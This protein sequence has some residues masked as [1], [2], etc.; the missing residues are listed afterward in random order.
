MPITT[1]NPWFLSAFCPTF[2]SYILGTEES[3]KT[4]VA[5][6]PNSYAYLS[7][8]LQEKLPARP[9]VLETGAGCCTIAFF[10]FALPGSSQSHLRAICLLV[11]A[12]IVS[13]RASPPRSSI[14]T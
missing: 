3:L 7:R 10:S 1:R 12:N 11:Y 6:M 14:V 9:L 8:F 2:R 5:L 13:S 4:Q